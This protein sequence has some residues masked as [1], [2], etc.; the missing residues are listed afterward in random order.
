[1]KHQKHAKLTRRNIGNFGINEVAIMGTTCGDIKAFVAAVSEKM[2]PL[3]VAFMDMD[4]KSDDT[5]KENSFFGETVVS[6][7]DKINFKRFDS[8]E[9]YTS[10]ELR[11]LFKGVDIT[12]VNGNHF[13]GERQLLFVDERKPL[14]KKVAKIKNPIAL[15]FTDGV[16]QLPQDLLET[17]PEL[18]DL[19]SFKSNDLDGI[20]G[21]LQEKSVVV[22]KLKGLVLVGGKSARMGKDKSMLKYYDD[23]QWKHSYNLLSQ[24]CDEVFVSVADEKEQFSEVKQ[25]TDKFLG[26]GPMGGILS[27]F[28]E[29]PNA[30][31]LVVACDLPLLSTT[32]LDQL[33][34]NRNPQKFA[35]SFKSPTLGFPEPLICIWEPRSYG[36]LLEFLSWGYSCPRKALINSDIELL[37]A[38]KEEE[39]TNV[40]TPEEYQKINS[41]L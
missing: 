7:T 36:R 19:P 10:F 38:D 1:M 20:A 25:I 14:L 22:P 33:V 8:L 34:K 37:I 4:H 23:P 3:K 28:Q 40:N 26:L 17:K 2:S 9:N 18:A 15:V 24:Y 32:S 6:Y 39:M 31:W 11:T 41:T 30:A 13:E 27:S 21:F 12:L 29:D 35:T 5:E 16:K